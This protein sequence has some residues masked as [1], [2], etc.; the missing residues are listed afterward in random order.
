MDNES[1]RSAGTGRAGHRPPPGFQGFAQYTSRH[2][3]SPQ[4]HAQC[5][6][7]SDTLGTA[8]AVRRLRA[9]FDRSTRAL[10]RGV[11]I[12]KTAAWHLGA[13]D[14]SAGRE[15][16]H[17][18]ARDGRARR[19]GAAGAGGRGRHGRRPGQPPYWRTSSPRGRCTGSSGIRRCTHGLSRIWRPCAGG[20]RGYR[21]VHL[22]KGDYCDPATYASCGLDLRDPLVIVNYP[23]G[24]QHRLAEF[25]A[26]HA[27][28][29]ATLCLF[30]HDR[31]LGI[32]ELPL[33]RA[34]RRSGWTAHHPW[35]L[36]VYRKPT[37]RAEARAV[38]A[39]DRRGGTIL[40]SR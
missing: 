33:Q 19:R 12:R 15:G 28:P 9:V 40:C 39:S 11:P 27:A 17:A 31:S 16:R 23:D 18:A 34:A 30:T 13:V 24:N 20:R 7:R 6:R 35:R 1:T 38:L 3:G 25:V 2:V 36:S 8:C 4:N 26:R 14:D 10:A 21:A 32:D 29:G 22:V 5:R 37:A